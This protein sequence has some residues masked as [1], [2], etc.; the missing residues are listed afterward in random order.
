[1]VIQASM[2]YEDTKL[3]TSH[4]AIPTDLPL[5]AIREFAAAQ[6]CGGA[7]NTC[8]QPGRLLIAEPCEELAFVLGNM[9]SLT[10]AMVQAAARHAGTGTDVP[11]GWL[12]FLRICVSHQLALNKHVFAV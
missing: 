9:T 1:M 3:F 8:R 5:A 6:P 2:Y 12:E 11:P 4:E 10:P 7:V